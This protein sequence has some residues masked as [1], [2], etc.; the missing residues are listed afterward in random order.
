MRVPQHVS[1]VPASAGSQRAITFVCVCAA[2]PHDAAAML[3]HQ[4]TAPWPHSACAI[5]LC[6]M[7]MGGR[8]EL[9]SPRTCGQFVVSGLQCRSDPKLQYWATP[10]GPVSL[11]GLVTTG[12]GGCG[13]R[14]YMFV[15]GTGM[16][17]HTGVLAGTTRFRSERGFGSEEPDPGEK[18]RAR[19]ISCM[20][21]SHL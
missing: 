18:F 3:E 5:D 21:V 16:K 6:T 2:V 19:F 11:A 15:N 12:G 1:S 4:F 9:Y 20:L 7:R 10:M 13:D 8:V 17:H 14:W